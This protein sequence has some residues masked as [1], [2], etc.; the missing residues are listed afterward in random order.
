MVF[1]YVIGWRGMREGLSV[2]KSNDRV[3]AT[4]GSRGGGGATII[5]RYSE[6]RTIRQNW[7]RIDNRRGMSTY[8]WME[9]CI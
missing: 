9:G 5:Y 7:R 2:V 8:V 6:E 3:G 4:G 1:T